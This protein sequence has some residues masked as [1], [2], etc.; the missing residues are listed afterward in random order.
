MNKNVEKYVKYQQK[1]WDE[2]SRF[3]MCE[4]YGLGSELS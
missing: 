3:E 2:N 1:Q 4:Y